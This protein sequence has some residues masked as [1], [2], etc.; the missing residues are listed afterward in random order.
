MRPLGAIVLGSYIDHAGRRKG[1]IVTLGLMA[2]GTLSVA[3][4][5]SYAR[6]G[7][8]APLLIVAGRLVQGFWR[9][10]NSDFAVPFFAF[11]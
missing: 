3:V 7:I 9:A 4:V 11:Q 1:L 10:S 5:P 6:I 2:L 8:L